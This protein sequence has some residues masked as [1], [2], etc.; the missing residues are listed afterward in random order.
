MKKIL[1]LCIHILMFIIIYLLII[2]IDNSYGYICSF[3]FIVLLFIIDAFSF[4]NHIRKF[5][6]ND[7]NEYK[8]SIHKD[9]IAEKI[10]NNYVI[11]VVKKDGLYIVKSAINELKFN[12]KGCLFPI[13]YVKAY[14]IRNIHFPIYNKN[15]YSILK[16]SSS[17][18]V[19]RQFKYQN[20]KIKFIINGKIKEYWLIK[21]SKTKLNFIM[22]EIIASP[23]YY[24]GLGNR[25]QLSDHINVNEKYYA[26]RK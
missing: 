5:P 24:L 13:N 15:K 26:N 25:G 19:T 21:N 18:K 3:P 17:L 16:L 1:F 23:F 12:L 10:D 2:K 9:I 6:L 7:F 8:F 4:S 14:F 20:L 22:R 11:V